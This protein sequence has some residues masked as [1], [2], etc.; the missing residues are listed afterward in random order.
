MTK[1]FKVTYRDDDNSLKES[2]AMSMAEATETARRLRF[3]QARDVHV[4]PA[5]RPAPLPAHET[6]SG[7]SR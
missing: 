7:N 6:E 5:V 3:A 1:R 2:K 4:V